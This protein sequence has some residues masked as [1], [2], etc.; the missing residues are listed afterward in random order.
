MYMA[1]PFP[2]AGVAAPV[3][4][5]AV[6]ASTGSNR[7]RQHSDVVAGGGPCR[8]V[9]HGADDGARV[10][11]PP[12]DLLVEDAERHPL[13]LGQPRVLSRRRRVPPVSRAAD[14]APAWGP[15]VA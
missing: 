2:R 8:W 7:R 15:A 10:V 9:R 11:Q 6:P 4:D 1:S 13:P 5:L 3:S 14:V 12:A